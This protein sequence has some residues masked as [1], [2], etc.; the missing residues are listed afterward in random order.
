MSF[1]H[2]EMKNE[3]AASANEE[4][5]EARQQSRGVRILVLCCDAAANL[6]RSEL[7]GVHLIACV[8]GWSQETT[9]SVIEGK[10]VVSSP[11]SGPIPNVIN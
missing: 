8:L 2:V 5:M 6:R 7:M 1:F 9:K 11:S 4:E 3:C 10:S